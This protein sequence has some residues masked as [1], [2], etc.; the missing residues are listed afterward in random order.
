[1]T[2]IPALKAANLARWNKCQ[3]TPSRQAE[4]HSVATRLC[5]VENKVRFQGVSD[6]L[7]ELAAE[8]SAIHPVPWWF[9]AIVSEREY[10]PDRHGNQRWD[11]QL[12][13]GDPLNAPSVHVPKGMG[14]YLDHP[15][16]STPGHDAWTRC[17][18]DVLINSAPFAAKWADWSIG[19][20]LTLFIMYNGVGYEMYHNEPSPYDWG[21]TNIEQRGKYSGD[22]KFAPNQWDTQIGCAA[23]LKGMMAID[24]TIQFAEAA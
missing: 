2:D 20:S 19:G 14:G 17:C 8:N 23:M 21:A 10:G 18:V 5:T 13:Q 24:S 3:I 16:D 12:G 6:R 9:V 11:R 7:A 22:G 1:M 15:S 4:V